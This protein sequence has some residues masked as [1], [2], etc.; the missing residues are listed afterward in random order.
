[1]Q[2][3]LLGMVT[4]WQIVEQMILIIYQLI[5]ECCPG[6]VKCW[7][8]LTHCQMD[9]T[10]SPINTPA[11]SRSSEWWLLPATCWGIP[12]V[13]GMIDF[14]SY[15]QLPFHELWFHPLWFFP[16][17]PGAHRY[18]IDSIAVSIEGR[19]SYFI[20]GIS[21]LAGPCDEV[22]SRVELVNTRPRITVVLTMFISQ[23]KG[24]A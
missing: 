6:L 5:S 18:T 13:V 10:G 21:P 24:H 2:Q 9:V 20:P 22:C 14:T 1:M 12:A 11:D 16:L 7:H 17:L 4:A 19:C 3:W 8:G 23:G 15:S